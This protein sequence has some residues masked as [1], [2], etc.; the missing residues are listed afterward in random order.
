MR[1]A[2]SV[3]N[4][5]VKYYETIYLVGRTMK[6]VI[7]ASAIA[8]LGFGSVASAADLPVKAPPAP[9]PQVW[10]WSGF[11]IGGNVGGSF[12]DNNIDYDMPF[13][14]PGNSFGSCGVVTGT[15]VLSGPN[16]F[17]LSSNC[18]G[19]SSV[20]GGGQ[21]G[22]NWQMA[23][24][25]FGLEADGEWQKV[26]AH[27][28]VRFGSN[29]AAGAPMGSVATDTAYFRSEQDAL[30]T[31][32]GRIGWSGGNWLVYA[33]G[34]LAVGGVKHSATEVLSPGIA[35]PVV[36]GNCRTGNDSTTKWGWTVGA[37]SE[38]MLDRN[39]SVGLEYLY[40][41]LGN[42]T[43][44]LAPAG[45]FFFNTSSIKFDDREHIVRL[46]LNYHFNTPVIAKY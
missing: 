28:F 21:I 37:G 32:R 34:G 41:D 42:S 39:W 14:T 29:P 35:C 6:K 44:T 10:N 19:G 23:A 38:L 2:E 5:W 43:I 45:G 1:G 17:D 33:T 11:Y 13:T 7:L 26:I 9:V 36:S 18:S 30:G 20:I 27:S 8:V 16:P 3:I 24:W 4:C 25:V 12:S 15:P 31:F 40:V 22:Y 46:K